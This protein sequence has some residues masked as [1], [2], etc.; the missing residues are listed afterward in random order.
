M[1]ILQKS[2]VTFLFCLFTFP[3][4]I[5]NSQ[6]PSSLIVNYKTDDFVLL[7]RTLPPK[8]IVGTS[9]FKLELFDSVNY[10][11]IPSGKIK[12]LTSKTEDSNEKYQ[13]LAIKEA[14]ES[15]EYHANVT[16]ETFG[17]WNLSFIVEIDGVQYP[18][19][20]SE[21]YISQKGVSNISYGNYVFFGVLLTI[22]S[23]IYILI[24]TSKK[25][26]N[27]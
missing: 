20:G 23:I 22:I 7:V 19:I 18:E 24:K 13:V 3:V 8:P 14:S 12:I 26:Q 2:L 21:I 1:I 25:R 4:L 9:Y 16:F 15:K 5:L 6:E 27:N 10:A 17:D 11:P